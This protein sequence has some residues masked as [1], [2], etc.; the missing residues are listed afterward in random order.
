MSVRN[1]AYPQEHLKPRS[2]SKAEFQRYVELHHAEWCEEVKHN[3]IGR[4][5]REIQRR[6]RL[7]RQDAA[8]SGGEAHVTVGPPRGGGRDE[9]QRRDQ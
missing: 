8:V 3:Y 4:V 2:I 1:L 7:V 9:L 6:S 5:T